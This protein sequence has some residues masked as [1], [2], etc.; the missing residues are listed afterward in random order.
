M[1]G[2]SQSGIIVSKELHRHLEIFGYKKT[3]TPGFLRTQQ[4]T[5]PL[6]WWLMTSES[7]TKQYN[8]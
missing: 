8:I 4:E 3:F 2:L 5:P 1:H 7:T 6:Q